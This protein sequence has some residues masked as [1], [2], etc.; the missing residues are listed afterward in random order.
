MKDADAL[1]DILGY[2]YLVEGMQNSESLSKVYLDTIKI[3]NSS[4]KVDSVV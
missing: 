2:A 4:I 1:N 3:P